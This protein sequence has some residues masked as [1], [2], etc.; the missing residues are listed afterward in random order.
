M[1]KPFFYPAST[2]VLIL[3]SSAPA[4]YATDKDTGNQSLG[5]PVGATDTFDLFCPSGTSKAR[6]YVQ[7]TTT[8]DNPS[9]LVRASIVKLAGAADVE[10]DENPAA[11]DGEG[12]GTSDEAEQ[13]GVTAY[14]FA[15]IKL[16]SNSSESYKG[17]V[18][19]YKNGAWVSANSITLTRRQNQ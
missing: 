16:T 14:T 12:G 6:V 10:D 8:T 19:C 18:G 4:V 15:V 2:L 3:A 11:D 13:T 7:D 17:Y 5:T 9:A 1:K